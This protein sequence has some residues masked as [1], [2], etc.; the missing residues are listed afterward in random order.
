MLNHRTKHVLFQIKNNECFSFWLVWGET[1]IKIL[2]RELRTTKPNLERRRGLKVSKS[3]RILLI[4]TTNLRLKTCGLKF[5]NKHTKKLKLDR[6]VQ[7][8]PKALRLLKIDAT[9][10]ICLDLCDQQFCIIINI[11]LMCNVHKNRRTFMCNLSVI[12]SYMKMQ[13]SPSFGGNIQFQQFRKRKWVFVT[14]LNCLIPISLQ[15]DDVNLWYF[16][17]RLFGLTEFIVWNIKG[18]RHWVAKI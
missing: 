4:N 10:Y 5:W 16:K 6:A 2:L 8:K 9:F 13:T 14:N 18:P 15:S 12:Y 17:L 11:F 7:S 1:E 3:T